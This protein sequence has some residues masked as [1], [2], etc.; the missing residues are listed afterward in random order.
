M[1]LDKKFL[2]IKVLNFNYYSI[3]KDFYLKSKYCEKYIK[4]NI[5]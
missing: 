2:K 1:N 3:L 4:D 5:F